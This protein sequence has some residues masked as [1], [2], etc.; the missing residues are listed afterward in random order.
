MRKRTLTAA[1]FMAMAAPTVLATLPLSIT[2][3][4]K[5]GVAHIRVVGDISNW[6]RSATEFEANVDALVRQGVRNA[7]VYIRTRGGD[8]FEANE[9]ANVI[10]RFKGRITGTGGAMVASAGTHLAMH[11]HS[12]EMASNGMWMYHKPR[13][14]F[15]GTEAEVAS[16]LKLLQDLTNQYRTLYAKKT[17][18]SEDEIEKR[19]ANADVWLTAKEAMEQGFITGIVADDDYDAEDVA[20]MAAMGAPEDKLKIAAS[21]AK[22]EP[23]M[24]IKA[25]RVQLGMPETA[26]EQEVLAKVKQLQD[27]VTSA[28]AA[29]AQVRAAEVKS[30]IDAAV[31]D[32]KITEAHRPGFVSKFSADFDATKA[33][34][35]AIQPVVKL[36]DVEPPAG[37]GAGAGVDASVAAARKAW[38][39]DAW[40]TK[41]M[42]GLNAM[43]LGPK[44]TAAT[45]AQFVALYQAKY[46]KAPELPA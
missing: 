9:M 23:T 7:H 38:D 12:F 35:E 14:S 40:A 10:K 17:G 15:E 34:L 5:N 4:A 28:A 30:L 26:T 13:G 24:D 11:L 21:A 1:M 22:Q 44:A 16:N 27:N 6:E 8:V 32:R 42:A 33:E 45:K 46:G 25:L 2:C 20:A 37:E 31:N 29:A 3:E 36:A 19:W 41:D 43:I 39:Y 18:L